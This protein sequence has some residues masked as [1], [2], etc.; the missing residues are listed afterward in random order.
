[1]DE[2]IL[3]FRSI[4]KEKLSA[5]RYEHVI[6]VSFLSMALA[7]KYGCDLEK[8]ELAGLLHDCAKGDSDEELLKKCKKQKL[9]LTEEECKAPAVLHAKY[10][11]WLAKH[12]YGVEEKDVLEAIRWHT[13]GK[14]EMSLLEKIVFTADYIEPRRNNGVDLTFLRALA[15]RDLNECVYRILENTLEYLKRKGRFV[16]SCSR[17]AYLYYRDKFLI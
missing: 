3:M 16:D 7:M 8:A 2:R 13:T 12:E 11:E 17:E 5:S 14:P 1:M 4:L 10:G 15:F 6:S 9:P